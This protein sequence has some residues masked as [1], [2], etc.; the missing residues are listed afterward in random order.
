MHDRIFTLIKEDECSSFF[1]YDVIVYSWHL[2]KISTHN[3][4]MSQKQ[5]G[6]YFDRN[7]EFIVKIESLKNIPQTACHNY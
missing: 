1:A 6:C 3:L 4:M 5:Y 2:E 7:I